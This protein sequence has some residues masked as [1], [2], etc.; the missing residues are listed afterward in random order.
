VHYDGRECGGGVDNKCNSDIVGYVKL[1]Y[2]VD[3]TTRPLVGGSDGRWVGNRVCRWLTAVASLT[4]Y[5]KYRIV[6]HSSRWGSDS[7][8]NTRTS[9]M[10]HDSGPRSGPVLLLLLL[11]L[12]MRVALFRNH[13]RLFTRGIITGNKLS[14]IIGV[15]INMKCEGWQLLLHREVIDCFSIWLAIT[16]FN[17]ILKL[18]FH[19]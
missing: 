6:Q 15:C 9:V 5:T 19:Y 2:T 14:Y 17:R 1:N 8:T 12:L 4:V 7:K 11:L 13:E 18:T 10:S 16:L 3:C